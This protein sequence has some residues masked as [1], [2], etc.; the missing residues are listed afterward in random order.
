MSV[1]GLLNLAAQDPAASYTILSSGRILTMTAA[2]IGVVGVAF[3]WVALA[4][5]AG[6]FGTSTGTLGAKLTLAAGLA[7]IA[8]GAVVVATADGGFGTGNG[9]A[10][11]YVAI[12]VGLIALGIGA[13]A[14]TRARRTSGRAGKPIS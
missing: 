12:L 4:R 6:R 8:I 13:K 1:P 9:L 10:G 2:L 7:S 14:L 5:P 11:A 3:G